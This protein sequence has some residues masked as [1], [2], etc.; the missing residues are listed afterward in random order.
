MIKLGQHDKADAAY[1]QL[2]E[3]PKVRFAR[4]SAKTANRLLALQKE[5]RTGEVPDKSPHAWGQLGMYWLAK[6]QWTST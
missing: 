5:E 6:K 3:H 1:H 2:V 4:A